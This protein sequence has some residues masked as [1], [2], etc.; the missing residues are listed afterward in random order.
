MFRK[1]VSYVLTLTLVWSTWPVGVAVSQEISDLPTLAEL[2]NHLVDRSRFELDARLDRLDYD[3][4]TIIRFVREEIAFQQYPGLLRGARGTLMS[5]AGNALDQS[6]LLATLLKDAGYDARIHQGEIS[7]A[8]ARQLLR[9][10][11]AVMLQPPKSP[12]PRLLERFGS[13]Q[14]SEP[15]DSDGDGLVEPARV[16]FDAD[17]EPWAP[18]SAEQ[19][20]KTAAMLEAALSDAG[21]QLGDPELLEQI[22]SEAEQYFWVSYREGP[23]SKWVPVQPVFISAG[24]DFEELSASKT[25]SGEVPA[26]LQHRVRI[27]AFIEQKIGDELRIHPIMDPW[28]RPAANL[29]GVTLYFANQPSGYTEETLE[30]GW[31]TVFEESS[32][33]VPILNGKLAPGGRA[34]DRNGIPFALD[35][36]GMDRIGATALFQEVGDKTEKAA[37]ALGAL[38]KSEPPPE[39]LMALTAQWIDYTVIVPGREPVTHRRTILDRLGPAARGRGRVEPLAAEASYRSLMAIEASLV[40]VGGYPDD[41]IKADLLTINEAP[42]SGQATADDDPSSEL[43]VPLLVAYGLFERPP[44]RDESIVAYRSQPGLLAWGV[45]L[46]PEADRMRMFGDIVHA[47]RRYLRR[48]AEGLETAPRAAIAQ[49]VWETLS[50][51]VIVL[52]TRGSVHDTE[53]LFSAAAA[54]G[55]GSVL[56][57]E[58][59]PHA[60]GALAFDSDIKARISADL[61]RGFAAL[62]L[63]HRPEGVA[64]MGWWRIDPASG[65]VLGMG[66]EGRGVVV[67]EF[68]IFLTLI[69][70]VVMNAIKYDHTERCANEDNSSKRYPRTGLCKCFAAADTIKRMGYAAALKFCDAA[71]ELATIGCQEQ[72]LCERKYG[73]ES[74]GTEIEYMKACVETFTTSP[75][76]QHLEDVSEKCGWQ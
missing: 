47:Q 24:H 13:T 7:R 64:E 21:V 36:L 52:G 68:I 4:P 29:H 34:F 43:A 74:K 46:R 6:V 19:V 28:E 42:L 54:S 61:E 60:L 69:S 17:K 51:D 1:F 48:T 18:A 70:Y 57:A 53:R 27:E 76:T 38:G 65:H 73:R 59:D 26:E 50:E 71:A 15:A 10:L 20:E 5:R 12:S 75:T 14:D 44:R 45:S 49:G 56:L 66:A 25:L 31:D 40:N 9:E 62:V 22:E 8:Q 39:E 37:S 32:L 35:S 41:F 30:A 23:S 33:F 63:E 67:T 55:I 72:V 2:E 11:R 3:A 58:D 16:S